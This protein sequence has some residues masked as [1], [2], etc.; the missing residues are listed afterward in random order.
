MAR[1][2]KAEREKTEIG[3]QLLEARW[4]PDGREYVLEKMG[5]LDLKQDDLFVE[6]RN[7]G[8]K[9]SSSTLKRWLRDTPYKP[10]GDELWM[11]VVV[12]AGY[13]GNWPKASNLSSP[14]EA[15][16]FWFQPLP[17]FDLGLTPAA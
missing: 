5:E 2:T 10:D 16:S 11:L 6:L 15:Y 13:S 12:L 17:E 7:E 4:D 14:E 8:W 3:L 9:G 1:R